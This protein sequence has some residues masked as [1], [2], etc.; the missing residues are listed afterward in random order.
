MANAGL[1]KKAA[2]V[3]PIL[4]KDIERAMLAAKKR[5][6]APPVAI[7][8]GKQIEQ[9][10]LIETYAKDCISTVNDRGQVVNKAE[11]HDFWGSVQEHDYYVEQGY[12]PILDGS[13]HHLKLKGGK[14]FAYKLPMELYEQGIRAVAEESNRIV[15]SSQRN[16][17]DEDELRANVRIEEKKEVMTVSAEDYEQASR[18]AAAAI[19]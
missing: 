12:I 19:D 18:E 16:L 15:G 13:G 1:A 2:V 7:G 3:D 6:D 8:A 9:K 11:Y 5:Q 4:A 14:T 17:K 10:R